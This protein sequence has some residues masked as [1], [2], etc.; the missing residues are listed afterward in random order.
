M[1]RI[2]VINLFIFISRRAGFTLLEVMI[3]LAIVGGLLVTLLYTLNHHLGIAGRHGVITLSMG[4][5]KDKLY[6]M[7][8]NPQEGK[9]TFPEPYSAFSFETSVKDAYFNGFLE[10]SVSVR[11]GN[12]TVTLSELIRKSR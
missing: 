11:N 4:L 10:L 2:R 1:N 12:E 3:S 7:E 9:G 5:A 8:K 6:E